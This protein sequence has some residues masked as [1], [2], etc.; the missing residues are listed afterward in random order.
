MKVTWLN[1]AFVRC[2]LVS[3]RAFVSEKRR[4]LRLRYCCPERSDFS[5]APV[6]KNEVVTPILTQR[7][8]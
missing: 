2:A 3:E 8:F 6:G 4:H 5:L 1:A 7:S